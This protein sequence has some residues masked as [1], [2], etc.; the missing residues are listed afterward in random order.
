M[1]KTLLISVVASLAINSFAQTTTK[2]VPT[3]LEVFVVVEI[4]PEFTG[5]KEA[6]Y[7]FI[8]DNVQYPVECKEN[9]IEGKVY[10]NFVVSKDGKIS[11]AKVIRS[12]NP[13]IDAEA[14]RLINSMPAWKPGTMR[15]KPVNVSKNLRINFKL[16]EKT[17]DKK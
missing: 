14:L 1:K 3:D 2:S 17:K 16:R 4:Q 6:M 11:K 5:G 9:N 10:V 15:G 13:L 7:K 12:V 8:A